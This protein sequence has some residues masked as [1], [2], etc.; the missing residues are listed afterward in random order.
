MELISSLRPEDFDITYQSTNRWNF[1]GNG[2]TQRD[3]NGKDITWYMGLVDGIDK[4][5]DYVV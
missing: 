1:L 4:Q 3:V 5:R 2:F